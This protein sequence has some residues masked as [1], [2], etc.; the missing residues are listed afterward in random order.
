MKEIL[1]L[2]DVN[3][4][5]IT[6]ENMNVPI[7]KQVDIAVNNGVKMIQYR[8]KGGTDREKFEDCRKIKEICEG[9][10]LFV[11]NDR[12]DIALAV[13]SDGVH[14]GQDD[15][16]PEKVREIIGD[17]ILGISTHTEEQAVEAQEFGDYIGIGPVHATD[18]KTVSSKPLGI[19]GVR[20]I[21]EKVSVPTTAIGGIGSDDISELAGIVDMV[22]AISSVTKHG[23]LGENIRRF[24]KEFSEEKR[25]YQDD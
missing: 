17:R 10:T 19:E 25:R 14:L 8:R 3:Y 6:D 23:N 4:Y 15:L 21:A 12:V 11:V 20:T 1:P 13:G 18:T 5:F 22:C 16:P 2:E 9:K 24:E 7:V